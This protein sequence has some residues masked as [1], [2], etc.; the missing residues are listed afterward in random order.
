MSAPSNQARDC[1]CGQ[2]IFFRDDVWA[3]CTG[4]VQ[5]AG[6]MRAHMPHQKPR[7]APRAAR[8]GDVCSCVCG[9]RIRFSAWPVKSGRWNHERR[10][11]HA[12][13]P[14]SDLFIK[15]A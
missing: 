11:A 4:R 14:N 5:C 12:A 8:I 2:L 7:P 10:T 9:A 3:D 6:T 15:S 1:K 13:V